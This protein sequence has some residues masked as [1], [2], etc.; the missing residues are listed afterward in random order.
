MKDLVIIT[1]HYPAVGKENFL[2]EEVPAL[3][4]KFNRV[5]IL[6]LNSSKYHVE[7]PNNV[8]AVNLFSVPISSK[9][10][11]GFLFR[12]L[13]IILAQCKFNLGDVSLF[14]KFGVYA[15][16]LN[17]WQRKIG[18]QSI[19]FY[20]YWLDEGAT[21]LGL[22]KRSVTQSMLISRAH[23]YDLYEEDYPQGL[24][25]FYDFSI[26]QLDEVVF[27]SKDGMTYFT[28]KHKQ[29]TSKKSVFYLGTKDHGLGPI[30]QSKEVYNIV[31]CS[32]II[33]LKRLE[34][35][36]EALKQVNLDIEWTHYGDGP[37]RDALI[38]K[39]KK[40]SN[41]KFVSDGFINNDD[42][43]KSYQKNA[44]HL[45]VNVSRTEG[46]PVSLIEAI[47]FG[48]P[49]LATNVRGTK[50]VCHE[51]TGVLVDRDITASQL[52]KEIEDCLK[53]DWDRGAIRRYWMD[54]FKAEDNFDNFAGYL[55][56]K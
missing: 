22:F 44:Y 53:Q 56:R 37:N 50:E 10:K 27:I 35:L 23:G 29:N 34:L 49:L 14:T 15:H 51:E 7:L 42:L 17:M 25:K 16:R 26:K 20:T 4:K 8:Q 47:S 30:P 46:L 43:L 52:A 39:I 55:E 3:A 21:I 45:F 54:N 38:E 48:I 6:P 40:V 33:P 5:F 24:P 28:E 13:L 41:V 1:N 19:L 36:A 11:W 9:E 32:S 2:N 31:T 18:S 12:N